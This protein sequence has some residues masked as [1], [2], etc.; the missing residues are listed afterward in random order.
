MLS[1]NKKEVMN[2]TSVCLY[3]AL[4]VVRPVA[5][6]RVDCVITCREP[7]NLGQIAKYLYHCAVLLI[8][9]LADIVCIPS[10]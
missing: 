1:V 8:S 9:P 4:L 6:T 10:W 5:D 3:E 7:H 2:R